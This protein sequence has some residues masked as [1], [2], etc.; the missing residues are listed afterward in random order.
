M[1]NDNDIPDWKLKLRYGKLETPYIHYTAL[2]EGRA[3]QPIDDFDCPV[4]LAWMASKMWATSNDQAADIIQSIAAQIG[5]ELSGDIK[6]YE[7]EAVN[8]PKND[9]YGYDIHFTPFTED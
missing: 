9:P 7:T 1:T 2:A 5:F 3:S 8:P 4:G 6:I